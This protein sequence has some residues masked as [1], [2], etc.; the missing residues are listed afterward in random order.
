M[1]RYSLYAADRWMFHGWFGVL[2]ICAAVA[3]IAVSTRPHANAADKKD[4]KKAVAATNEEKANE[5]EV[6][7]DA[8]AK[9]TEKASAWLEAGD[10]E[11]G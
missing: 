1:K 7:D 8:K 3:A 6:G 4:N 5:K 2:T 10:P 9:A 11:S